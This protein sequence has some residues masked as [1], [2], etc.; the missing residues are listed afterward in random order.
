MQTTLLS[1]PVRLIAILTVGLAG[2]PASSG[3][4]GREAQQTLVG[5]S[6]PRGLDALT[7]RTPSG[8]VR[9]YVE[10]PEA[11]VSSAWR[12]E[13]LR[14]DKSGNVPEPRPGFEL[15][16]RVIVRTDNPAP[17]YAFALSAPG[18]VVEPLAGVS[19]YWTASAGTVREAAAIAD[20][21]ADRREFAEV[22]LDSTPPRV[23]R[24][25]PNDP[26]FPEQWHLN[27]ELA[28]L[29]DVNAEAAWDAGYSGIGVVV[30][31]VEGAWQH[32]HPD[33]AD[34][35][36]A[37]AS[38]T[39]GSVTAH[40]T[41]CA[42]VAGEVAY[43]DVMGA[44]MAYGAELSSQLYGSA[45]ETAVALAYRNDLN[46][47]KSNSW[48][49]PDVG[50]VYYMPS[51]VRVAIEE[52][53]AT[54]RGGL[55]EVF[56]WAAGNGGSSDRVDY[57]PYV[58]SR[59]TLCVGAIGDADIRATY[60]ETGS[61]MLVVAQSSGNERRIHTTSSYSGWTTSFGGT[62]AASPLA[63]GVVALMLEANPGLTWRDVQ[64]VLIDSARMNDPDDA[65]WLTNTGGYDI[66]YNYGFGAV[67]AGAA[68]AVAQT[69]VNVPHELVIDTGV[70]AVDTP[71]P[72]NDPSGVVETASISDNIRIETVELILNVLTTFVGD[73]E[74]A[75]TGPSGVES[76]LARQRGG[77]SQDDYVDYIFTSF[78][79]WGEESAG[80]WTIN[81]SDRASGDLATWIDYR[82]V[83][84]G[85]PVCLGDLDE[86]GA[87]G[88][89]DLAA[90]LSAYGT[91]EGDAGFDPAADFDNTG[92]IDLADLSYLLSVYG[93]SCS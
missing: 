73:L 65:D 59:F 11:S 28:P 18:L 2:L 10:D 43:N 57:D 25:L 83:F 19:G 64:H 93:E 42:G 32:D 46:D 72:D 6:N 75:L 67:D 24:D 49:P 62:S 58:S 90:L 76:V 60:N 48:G 52:S 51:V 53:I 3:Q 50:D 13:T 54:G 33:L 82:L 91:C 38:Q 39:G 7:V 61:S 9:F 21:L 14:A 55:G 41:S 66:N 29:F 31:I 16:S 78:R 35:Y 12:D 71:I 20:D 30:G 81:I 45:L 74:I 44:G 69:W 8:V 89:G 79:H 37:D 34:N 40:A 56:V 80:D 22:Y 70:I 15:T 47:I 23:L 63:A 84:Y 1:A 68:V 77:D 4:N 26:R 92:C 17:L 27:N 87:I 86:D 85:T 88:L 36:N 5:V